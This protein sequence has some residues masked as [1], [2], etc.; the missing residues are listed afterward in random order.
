MVGETMMDLFTFMQQNLNQPIDAF[1]L[2]QRVT[3]EV[4]GKLAFGYRFGV[5]MKNI[6]FGLF[7]L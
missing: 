1:E 5:S 7:I 3:I 6:F 2:M 4:L